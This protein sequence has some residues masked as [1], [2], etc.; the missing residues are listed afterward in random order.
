MDKFDFMNRSVS[1][2]HALFALISGGYVLQQEWFELGQPNTE[3]Q[4]LV[5]IVACGYFLYDSIACA[6]AKCGN[7]MDAIHHIATLLGLYSGIL[8]QR[9]GGDLCCCYFLVS[10]SRSRTTWPQFLSRIVILDIHE[11]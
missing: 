10:L 5:L 3:L 6:V 8:F 2:V 1:V 7:M 11:Y 9:S 4:R